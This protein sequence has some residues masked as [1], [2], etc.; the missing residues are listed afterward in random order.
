[1]SNKLGEWNAVSSSDDNPRIVRT[2]FQSSVLLLLILL[3]LPSTG[4]TGRL[5]LPRLGIGD[6]L[7]ERYRDT[8]WAKRAFVLRYNNCDIPFADHFENGFIAGYCQQARG[9]DGYVPPLPPAE[10]RGIEFQ[11]E[12]G[13]KCVKAWFDG[14]PAGVAAAGK[15]RAGDY[16]SIYTSKMMVAAMAQDKAKH[17]L[18]DDVPVLKG[19][20]QSP[21][22]GPAYRQARLPSS[23]TTPVSTMSAPAVPYAAPPANA[24]NP[25]LSPNSIK[26]S[27]L[28]PAPTIRKTGPMAMRPVS[29]T[30]QSTI[31]PAVAVTESA[32]YQ[33][34]SASP[35]VPSTDAVPIVS[36][37]RQRVAA[38]PPIVSGR[39]NR[40][41]AADQTPL[42]MSFSRPTWA[43]GSGTL[44]R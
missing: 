7:L 41:T 19:S 28:E 42:P 30:S 25:I 37:N 17:I 22:A 43:A 36:G 14:F 34:Q 11:S 35:P 15:D 16:H 5:R 3:V 31:D 13:A 2:V 39:R 38:V 27:D 23:A 9:G 33:T 18:P 6:A 8:V 10:Y 21:A 32:T 20:G 12:D 44:Q 40:N 29:A 24:P 26:P 4:C 1:M